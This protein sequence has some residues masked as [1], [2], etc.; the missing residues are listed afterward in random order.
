MVSEICS[1]QNMFPGFHFQKH[2]LTPAWADMNVSISIF[3]FYNTIRIWKWRWTVFVA[4]QL[5]LLLVEIGSKQV[6]EQN[7][8]NVELFFSAI[9]HV[10][11]TKKRWKLIHVDSRF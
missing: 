3:F 11:E 9:K 10:S 1:I 6:F 7:F 4:T 8:R 2:D 5:R